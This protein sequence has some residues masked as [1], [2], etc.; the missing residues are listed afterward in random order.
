MNSE[1][2]FKRMRKGL[3]TGLTSAL[4]AVAM[5]GCSA[6]S[7]NPTLPGN[8]GG[9]GGG[10]GGGIT[11]VENCQVPVV[12]ICVLDPADGDGLVDQ[13]LDPNGPLGP[14][15][16]AVSVEGLT[17]ALT[18]LL[19]N[20]GDLASLL[21]NLAEGNLQEGL[22]ELLI[23]TDNGGG[24]ANI[25]AEVIR[26]NEDNE[27]AQ[28]LVG[29]FGEDGLPGLI[30]ALA[31]GGDADCGT[32]LGTIC[33]VS[34]GGS[35][36]G[37]VDLLLT[38]NG[39]L[40]ALSPLLT[41]EVTDNLVDIVGDIL[42][43]DDGALSTILSNALVDGNLATG[44]QALLIGNEENQGLVPTLQGLLGNLGGIIGEILGN[45]GRLFGGLGG[46]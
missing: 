10:G 42:A 45:I 43:S 22:Q 29:L 39:V 2:S 23:G 37:L 9:G 30:R 25:I 24:L 7:N 14:I 5:V 11:D 17:N 32:A 38:S 16:R 28:G 4:L 26:G 19:Q 40:G 46:N 18:T 41:Q 15:A 3:F 21:T 1:T 20:D 27:E 6:D 12:G 44:L 8:G 34:G 13:L 33:L 31:Q 35:Q 36:T